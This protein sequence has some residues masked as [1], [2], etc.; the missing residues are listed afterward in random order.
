MLCFSLGLSFFIYFF[1]QKAA[2][3]FHS[4]KARIILWRVRG[5]EQNPVNNVERSLL[6]GCFNVCYSFHLPFHLLFRCV[7]KNLIFSVPMPSFGKCIHTQKNLVG[8]RTNL[9]DPIHLILT[10][11]ICETVSVLFMM[12]ITINRYI[13]ILYRFFT[14]AIVH[15]KMLVAFPKN[16]CISHLLPSM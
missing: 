5:N 10:K 6:I 9:K 1:R 14:P 8:S 2:I 15:M 4:L 13:I 12:N 11:F 7:W 3:V 16:G